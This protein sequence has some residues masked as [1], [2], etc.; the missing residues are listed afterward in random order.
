MIC[1][2]DVLIE[3]NNDPIF[4]PAPLREY[5]DRWDGPSFIDEFCL[6]RDKEVLT[7]IHF[8]DKQAV[9]NKAA[10]PLK[11]GGRFVLSIDK[12]QSDVIDYNGRRV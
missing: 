3:E 6:T 11:P 4:A 2:Y 7:F 1:Y 5:M 9:I 8:S 12:N 10:G